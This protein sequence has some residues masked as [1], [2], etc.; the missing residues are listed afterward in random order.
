MEQDEEANKKVGKIIDL[1]DFVISWMMI[2]QVEYDQI[3]HLMQLVPTDSGLYTGLTKL[4]QWYSKDIYNI[5]VD[6]IAN[7]SWMNLQSLQ[8]IS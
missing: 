2:L 7:V 1:Y 8:M 3:I 6:Y 4:E 5:A